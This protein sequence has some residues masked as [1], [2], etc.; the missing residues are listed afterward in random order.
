MCNKKRQAG[1]EIDDLKRA[2][3]IDYSEHSYTGKHKEKHHALDSDLEIYVTAVK[4]R[5]EV[6]DKKDEHW[7]RNQENPFNLGEVIVRS[8]FPNRLKYIVIKNQK[9][10]VPVEV[11]T[12][13]SDD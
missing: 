9:S 6:S 10:I 7:H 11:Q 13:C 8:Q 1:Y 2:D 4:F 5:F 3:I 12:S